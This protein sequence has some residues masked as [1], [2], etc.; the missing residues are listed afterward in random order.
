MEQSLVIALFK[1]ECA[2]KEEVFSQVK[3]QA[4]SRSF[5]RFHNYAFPAHAQGSLA[6][7]AISIYK[8]NSQ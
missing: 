6:E 3:C 7:K 8:K 2:F 1:S 5:S 4:Q